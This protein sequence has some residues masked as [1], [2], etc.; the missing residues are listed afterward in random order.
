MRIKEN[1]ALVQELNKN[2]QKLLSTV[3]LDFYKW[4]EKYKINP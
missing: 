2:A 3:F 4:C 1:F